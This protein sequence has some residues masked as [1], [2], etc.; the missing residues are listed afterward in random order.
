VGLQRQDVGALRAVERFHEALMVAI[1]TVGHD[2]AEGHPGR[3]RGV[4]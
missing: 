2:R 1:E 4:H 3:H